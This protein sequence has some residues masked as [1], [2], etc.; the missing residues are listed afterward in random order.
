M[1]EMLDLFPTTVR[2][3]GRLVRLKLPAGVT[4]SAVFGGELQEYRY[5]LRRVWGPGPLVLFVMM[6]PST[7]DPLV[8]DPTVAKCGRFARKCGYGGLLVG[9][10][11][12]YRATDQA[13]LAE[14]CPPHVLRLSGDECPWHPLYLPEHLEPQR[15]S[16]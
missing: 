16:L 3:P 12:A 10:T 1:T 5:Q 9:N 14:L 11:F 6:N 13:R 15:W 8:D 7:A 4:G 2:D